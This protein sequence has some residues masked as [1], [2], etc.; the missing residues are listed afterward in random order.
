M[1]KIKHNNGSL[2]TIDESIFYDL[3]S[4]GLIHET[5]QSDLILNRACD[6]IKGIF[7]TENSVTRG[8]LRNRL[9]MDIRLFDDAIKSLVD[10]GFIK[11]EKLN[12]KYIKNGY[13]N[14]VCIK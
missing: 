2:Y 14:I 1:I 13:E 9:R 3:V 4:K 12:N 5:I 7:K 10:D 8:L 11:T 6:R